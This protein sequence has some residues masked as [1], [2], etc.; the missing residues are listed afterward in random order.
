MNIRRAFIFSSV[1]LS[2]GV[3]F[4]AK[5]MSDE[6][7]LRVNGGLCQT[8]G[9]E[10]IAA[11]DCRGVPNFSDYEEGRKIVAQ[12][13]STVITNMAMGSFT[14]ATASSMQRESGANVAVFI[15]DDTR[16]PLALSCPEERWSMLNA[17]K[18]SA[19]APCD[20]KFKRRMSILF[21]RQCCR[22]LGSDEGSGT[23][24]CFH[25]VLKLS[26]I[27]NIK[28]TDLTLNAM[29]SIADTM[30]LRGMEPIDWGTYRDACEAGRA[31]APTNEIQRKVWNQV[32]QIP[33][34][35]ITIEYD[36]KRDK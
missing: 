20:E 29:T 11:I 19:D 28:S 18:A 17:A 34:K 12:E 35:P 16:L 10:W 21:E 14:V 26:D 23:E 25:A 36:P 13:L 3:A 9:K 5:P 32:H 22:A 27:D 15:I 30:P 7:Y 4:A 33:D 2:L 24:T 1:A 31:H 6:E 8:K